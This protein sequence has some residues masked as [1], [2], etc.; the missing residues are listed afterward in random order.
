MDDLLKKSLE[1]ILGQTF[2]GTL[3]RMIG[4]GSLNLAIQVLL[5]LPYLEKA[6]VMFED[7]LME[8]KY[9]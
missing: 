6:G 5:N 2:N 9:A 1:N 8:H 4:K 3:T 7:L